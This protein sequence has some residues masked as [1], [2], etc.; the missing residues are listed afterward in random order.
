MYRIP[1]GA[2]KHLVLSYRVL[3][4]ALLNEF[5]IL[6]YDRER[7]LMS[8][9][10]DLPLET[11]SS[12][13]TSDW[14]L[15]IAHPIEYAAWQHEVAGGYTLCAF[16]PP[17]TPLGAVVNDWSLAVTHRA[18][19]LDWQHEVAGGYTLRSFS[20]WRSHLEN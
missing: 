9:T 5:Y 13:S 17:T 10:T 7:I 14:A 8:P 1:F 3:V 16:T 20:N 18:S 11:S 19:Y 12:V 6:I 15:A 4:C 2:Q